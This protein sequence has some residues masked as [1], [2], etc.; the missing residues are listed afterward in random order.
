MWI[1]V[2]LIVM[3]VVAAGTTAGMAGAGSST[4]KSTKSAKAKRAT[5]TAKR[6]WCKKH[7]RWERVGT[8][9]RYQPKR[10]T[11]TETPKPAPATPA[12][13]P[14][15]SAA[16]VVTPAPAPAPAPS[17]PT[18]TPVT[19]ST[20][21]DLNLSSGQHDIVYD[22]VTFK[23]SR[24]SQRATVTIT[25]AYNITI[26]NSVIEGSAWNAMSINSTGSVHDITLQNVVIKST[27][28]MG[29]ECT[30]RGS[31]GF[32]NITLDRV[33]VEPSGSEGISFDGKG[34][35]ITVTNTVIKGAGTRPD[36]F[37]WGQGFEINGNTNV[38][39]DG[40]TIYRTRGDGLNLSGPSGSCNWTFRNLLV[41]A[42]V[43]N[44]GSVSRGGSANL[45]YAKNMNGATF[46][47]R[48]N[49]VSGGPMGYLDNCDNNSLSGLTRSGS[50]ATV[51]QVNG[52]SGNSL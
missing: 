41:D 1:A 21:T 45:I 5:R 18:S 3:L 50:P 34:H 8:H 9:T 23:S 52:C 32:Y 20:I 51:S 46:Q 15:P 42:S 35:H 38:T 31:T 40:L 26:R 36:L 37:S 33:T 29:F 28:R 17:T 11:A 12:A 25:K 49:N 13:T 7:Q 14:K 10:P 47:G 22:G 44:L 30:E 16:P 4:C 39:V 6:C 2:S 48:L 24:A 19:N 43:N 27:Q